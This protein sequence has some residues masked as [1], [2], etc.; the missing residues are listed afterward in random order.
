MTQVLRE[1]FPSKK[2]RSKYVD[3]KGLKYYETTLDRY[4]KIDSDP[5]T[6]FGA[7]YV[8]VYQCGYMETETTCVDIGWYINLD[9]TYKNV[10]VSGLIIEVYNLVGSG[11]DYMI[12]VAGALAKSGHYDSVE[13]DVNPVDYVANYSNAFQIEV[14]I[15]YFVT[16]SGY[17]RLTRDS[18]TIASL[19]I[20]I[21]YTDD[22][23]TYDPSGYYIYTVDINVPTYEFTNDPKKVFDMD[24]DI[25][26]ELKML[27][28][29]DYTSE[30]SFETGYDPDSATNPSVVKYEIYNAD[31]RLIRSGNASYSKTYS[32]YP[33]SIDD[34]SYATASGLDYSTRYTLKVYMKKKMALGFVKIKI[35]FTWGAIIFVYNGKKAIIQA[36]ITGVDDIYVCRDKELSK[37]YNLNEYDWWYWYGTTTVIIDGKKN[38][39][40]Y[41]ECAF[42]WWS[43]WRLFNILI[44][45]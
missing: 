41:F 8:D 14:K 28:D 6:E 38:L 15:R 43:A 13:R 9:K 39:G 37:C 44:F 25:K 2:V 19:K 7:S 33:V 34:K 3:V 26:D 29:W 23:P 21:Y 10:T 11:V 24:T 45:D 40:Y 4:K 12:Y 36:K 27:A 5:Y 30:I 1:I 18:I 31:G 17:A 20:R 35:G 16:K 32:V 42:G 22:D